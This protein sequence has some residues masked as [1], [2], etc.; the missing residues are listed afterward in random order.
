MLAKGIADCLRLGSHPKSGGRGVG[1][2]GIGFPRDPAQHILR[3][4]GAIF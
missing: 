3:T 1:I 4:G 2:Q